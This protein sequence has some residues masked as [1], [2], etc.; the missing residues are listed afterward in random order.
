MYALL[1]LLATVATLRLQMALERG[2]AGLAA[3][4]GR[5]GRWRSTP[6]TTRWRWPAGTPSWPNARCSGAPT[7]C[8]RSARSCWPGWLS[9]PGG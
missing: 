7:A 3:P 1:G 2:A 8:A 6:T 4:R 5:P 9:C